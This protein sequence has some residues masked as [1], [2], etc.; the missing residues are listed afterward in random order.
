MKDIIVYT[1][2]SVSNNGKLNPKGGIGIFFS[3]NNPNNLG[4]Q[5]N[6][7]NITNN[8]CELEACRRA[9]TIIINTKNFNILTDKILICTDSIYLINSISLWAKNWE[10][11]NW[12]NSKNETIKNLN[13]IK[14]IRKYYL[15]YDIAFKYI[16]AH[17][18]KPNIKDI[19][20]INDI[21]YHNYKDWY[22]N[23]QADLLARNS[24][25]S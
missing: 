2:G 7:D 18:K 16:K 24:Y 22:G 6:I 25:S 4:L 11:N 5:L 1:D 3:D 20:D 9:I 8:I 15:K 14:E 13:L 21:N 17:Q 10:K 19:N 23:N 12:K